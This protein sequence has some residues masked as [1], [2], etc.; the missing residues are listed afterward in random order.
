M[1]KTRPYAHLFKTNPSE[2]WKLAAREFREKNP[3][4]QDR[5]R[6]KPKD[7]SKVIK[8]NIFDELPNDVIPVNDF[9][10]YYVRSNGEVWRDTRGKES[11]I[12]CGKARV[13]RLTPTYNAHNGYWLIQPYQDGKKKAIHLHRFILTA[14]KGPAPEVKMEC[15]HI[16]HD[17]SNNA[18]DNLMWVTRQEN[19]DY[20]PNYKRRVSKLKYGKGRKASESKYSSYLS[21]IIKLKQ[22][23]LRNVDIARKLEIN[24]G[25]VHQ[26][27]KTMRERGQI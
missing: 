26:I 24:E 20:V 7:E 23:G 15:H 3:N 11:A 10:T 13:L 2:Y 6:K 14:F 16:D 12:K 9:P 25:A 5:Y 8:D 4:Y 21:E 27:V 22:E 19:S 18:I 1:K 17:T